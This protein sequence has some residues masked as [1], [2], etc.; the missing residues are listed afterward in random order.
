M[1]LPVRGRTRYWIAWGLLLFLVAI[2]V[3]GDSLKPHGLSPEDRINFR[4]EMVDGKSTYSVPPF[5]PSTEFVLGTDHRGFDIL[6]LLL[7]GAKYTLGFALLVALTRFA[8]AVPLGLY[9]GTIGRGKSVL[10]MVALVTSAAPAMLFIFPT[11]YAIQKNA[12]AQHALTDLLFLMFVFFG[13]F[14]LAHQFA[15]RATFYNDKL[16]IAASRMMGASSS[17]IVFR[18]IFPHLRP[19]IL[20]TFLTDLGHILFLIGQLAVLSIFLGNSTSFQIDNANSLLLTDTGEWGAMIAYGVKYIQSYPW[21]L[22]FSAV[23]LTV[24]TFILW[25]FSTQLQKMQSDPGWLAGQRNLWLKVKENKKAAGIGVG[26]AVGLSLIVMMVVQTAQTVQ[27]ATVEQPKQVTAPPINTLGEIK[28]KT[29]DDTDEE[30]RPYIEKNMRH[31]MDA[32]AKGKWDYAALFVDPKLIPEGSEVPPK[33]FD[34]WYKLVSSGQ[35]EFVGIG[36]SKDVPLKVQLKPGERATLYTNT[37][38]KMK[39]TTT[40]EIEGWFV[41]NDMNSIFEVKSGPG[42]T[43]KK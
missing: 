29:T 9:I 24:A 22:G 28:I 20:F 3:F 14:Q 31:F 21:I 27:T 6:S 7:T 40:G 13:V 26:V 2:T 1:K 42:I 39:N 25:N 8:I 43:D 5:A 34:E 19:E 32:M 4:S 38:L 41:I 17:R 12:Q 36:V 33:P 11:L 18:H 35:Y 16:Y 10:S 37:E 23:F 15:E 30:T